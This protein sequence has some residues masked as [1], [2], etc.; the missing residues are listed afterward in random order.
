MGKTV[1]R[2]FSDSQ[3]ADLVAYRE[4]GLGWDEL[5]KKFNKKYREEK[6]PETLRKAHDKYRHMFDM[7]DIEHRVKTLQEVVSTK[8]RNSRVAKDNKELLSYIEMKGDLIDAFR[9]VLKAHDLPKLKVAK[10]SRDK[11]KHNMTLELMLSDIHYG[12]KTA[13]FN[14][15]KCRERMREVTRVTLEEIERHKMLYNVERIIVALLGDII[16]SFT[17]HGLESAAG[18]E[19]GNEEQIRAAIESLFYDV[20][21]PLAA[22]G[23]Q[24]DIPAVTGNHD[25]TEE[26]RTYVNPGKENVTWVIYNMLRMLSEAHGL[27]NVN[28]YIPEGSFVVLDIYGSTTLYEHGDNCKGTDRKTLKSWMADRGKQIGK[29]I[30]FFRLGHFHEYVMYGR[31]EI[32]ANESVPGPD[33]YS[34]VKGYNSQAGQTLNY[35]IETK[36]RPTSFFKSFPIYLK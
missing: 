36:E 8:R 16:E 24:I 11:T 6:S 18:C 2:A 27:K 25:R 10:I 1:S 21:L 4:A 23:I 29:I 19:V 3:L 31:G 15:E 34:D 12:K 26:H 7:S 20:I 22:T 35:Y 30:D 17:M 5:A 13:T 33:S 9:A 32:I 14:L 28:F